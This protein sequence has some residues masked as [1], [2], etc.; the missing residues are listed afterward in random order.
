VGLQPELPLT[1]DEVLITSQLSRRGAELP[2]Y[3][4]EK[5][6]LQN[7]AQ[8]MAEHPSEVVPRLVRLA[9]DICDSDSA[10]VSVLEAE[11]GVFRWE[12]LAGSLAVFE[13]V[14]TP[15]HSSPCGIC[16]DL[17]GPVLMERPERVYDWIRDAGISVPEVLLVPLFVHDAE[18]LGT[19][20]LVARRSGQ[21][22]QGHARVLTELATFAGLALSMIQTREKLAAALADQ[23]LLTREMSHRVKNFFAVAEGLIRATSRH[24]T[25]KEE[26]TDSLSGRF[27][28]LG[29]A[30]SLVRRS[31]RAGHGHP[32]GSLENVLWRVLSPYGP[33]VRIEGPELR[34]G[35]RATTNFAL[36]F[37]ELATN[38]FKHGALSR[39]DGWLSV[40]WL[41]EHGTIHIRWQESGGPDVRAPERAGFGS[42]LVN[43]AVSSQGG[44]ISYDWNP[45]GLRVLIAAPLERVAQ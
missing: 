12:G 43:S 9:M 28:A 16:L 17:G 24:S 35:E 6:A 33:A 13:G 34:L 37:H 15:R 45:D 36:V 42:V 32:G 40:D 11:T 29:E 23:E 26:M 39:S 3:R 2:D 8:V 38:A 25:T 22:D 1:V 18:P 27:R 31:A 44:R 4:R 14:T 19:L 41:Q 30:H 5:L 7:L 10:G 21:F 20:W